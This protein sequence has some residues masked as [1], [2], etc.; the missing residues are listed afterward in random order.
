[1][2]WPQRGP[3]C[4]HC[5]TA[6]RLRLVP[7]IPSYSGHHAYRHWCPKCKINPFPAYAPGDPLEAE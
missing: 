4:P 2:T 3:L 7:G 5:K 6:V 1:M